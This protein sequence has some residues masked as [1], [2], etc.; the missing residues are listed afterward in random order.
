[1]AKKF[2]RNDFEL[3]KAVDRALAAGSEAT[4]PIRKGLS[5]VVLDSGKARFVHRFPWA[6]GYPTMWLDGCY[7]DDVTITSALDWCEANNLLLEDGVDP[8]AARDTGATANPTLAEY[9]RANYERLAPFADKVDY[10]VERSRWMCDLTKYTGTL[11][12]MKIDAIRAEH[13]EAVLGKYW[14]NGIPRPTARRIA[15]QLAK[16]LKH[17]HTTQRRNAPY[18]Q[19]P[20][21]FEAMCFILGEG[22]HF[23]KPRPALPFE[24]VPAFVAGLRELEG[25]PARCLEWVIL[26]GCR[27]KEATGARWC[28]LD[29]T[30][31]RTW[32]IPA[33]RLKSERRKGED[34]A[35]FVVPLS[36][37]MCRLLQRV[38]KHREGL[39][40]GPNDFIF[41]SYGRARSRAGAREAGIVRRQLSNQALWYVVKALNPDI[42]THGFRSS[43]V[44]WGKSIPHRARPPFPLAVMDRAIGHMIGAKTAAEENEARLSQALGRYARNGQFGDV[45]LPERKLVM[46]EWSAYLNPNAPPRW[47]GSRVTPPAKPEPVSNVTAFPAGEARRAA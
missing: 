10:G 5:C 12:R 31:K 15:D 28:E 1:V 11:A 30:G 18:W 20:A 34:G 37:A 14:K 17:R 33:S 27:A 41:P 38:R 29:L 16:V 6:G 43:F 7:P 24:L 44:A 23:H 47:P 22:E 40:L 2:Y 21:D 13:V 26:T 42:C 39:D 32:T 4:F 3:K 35:P 19:N 45:F 8:R 36:Y 9:C 46:R 25:M